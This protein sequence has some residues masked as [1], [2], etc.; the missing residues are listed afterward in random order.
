MIASYGLI[1]LWLET[2]SATMLDEHSA[3][4]DSRVIEPL[5]G[6]TTSPFPPY[7]QVH[8]FVH[9][10]PAIIYHMPEGPA[11]RLGSNGHHPTRTI[12]HLPGETSNN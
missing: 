12:P 9:S 3:A 7:V 2:R 6:E 5:D 4:I 11:S 10:A 1:T 8:F